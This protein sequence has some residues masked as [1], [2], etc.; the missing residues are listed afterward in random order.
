MS[1]LNNVTG[2][3]EYFLSINSW[4]NMFK[5]FLIQ[6]HFFLQII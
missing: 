4:N 5:D 6:V 2:N 1:K 3:N